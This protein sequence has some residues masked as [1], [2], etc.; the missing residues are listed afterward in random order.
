M[1]HFIVCFFHYRE[2]LGENTVAKKE[3]INDMGKG[4]VQVEVSRKR[5]DKLK[6]DGME[7]VTNVRV[8]GD[9]REMQHRLEDTENRHVRLERLASVM[10][11]K[12]NLFIVITL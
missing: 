3:T 1:F 7:L 9:A 8:A 4:K 10:V 6:S 5:L 11:L 12:K 2:A